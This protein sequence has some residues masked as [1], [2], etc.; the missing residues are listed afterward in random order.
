MITYPCE[1]LK[2]LVL[3]KDHVLFRITHAHTSDAV[4]V[5]MTLL[6]FSINFILNQRP[7]V[8]ST[9]ITETG[10]VVKFG[11]VVKLR[12]IVNCKFESEMFRYAVSDF[13]GNI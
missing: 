5:C 8:I 1:T 4:E 3:T 6:A 9:T 10:H 7:G 12:F 11:S 13:L 2:V